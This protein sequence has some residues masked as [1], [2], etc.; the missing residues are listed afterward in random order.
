MPCFKENGYSLPWASV[1]DVVL[2]QL[3]LPGNGPGLCAGFKTLGVLTPSH[4][5][6]HFC[7]AKHFF[8]VVKC[9]YLKY[10]RVNYSVNYFSLVLRWV[11]TTH[12]SWAAPWGFSP[13]WALVP[14]ICFVL[15]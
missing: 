12:L 11:L 10:L 9:S 3:H 1:I 15:F 4:L 8:V 5:G 2:L 13:N 14:V 6:N 7:G